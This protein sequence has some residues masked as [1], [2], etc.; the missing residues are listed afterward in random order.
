MRR[1][2]NY[3]AVALACTA[4]I[5]YAWPTPTILYEIIVAL[6]LVL[7][8]LLLAL[9][10]PSLARLVRE[11]SAG[12]R[13][14]WIVLLIGG[15]LGAAVIYTGARRQE[16]PILYSHIVASLLGCAVLFA[17]FAGRRGWLGP[18]AIR[19]MLRMALSLAVFAGIAGAA[20]WVRTVPWQARLRRSTTP[21]S[22]PPA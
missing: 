20:W 13:L 17:A 21:K 6:H 2:L 10:I 7:G 14:G 9:A 18:G 11:G 4:L 15:A 8:V 22:R 19:A 16:W 12:E 1:A 5:L 3:L